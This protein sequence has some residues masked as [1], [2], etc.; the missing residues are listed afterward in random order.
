M[1]EILRNKDRQLAK[2]AR[3]QSRAIAD[4]SADTGASTQDLLTAGQ[5]FDAWARSLVD[6]KLIEETANLFKGLD[7][8]Y[9]RA[10]EVQKGASEAIFAIHAVRET[11]SKLGA[12]KTNRERREK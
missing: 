1:Q 2:E 3:V 5:D 10:V 12:R 7:Y 8:I 11:L 9:S 4:A 6:E